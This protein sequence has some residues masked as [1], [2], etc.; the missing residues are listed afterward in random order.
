M[1]LDKDNDV[2]YYIFK[3]VIKLGVKIKDKYQNEWN[4][5]E[6]KTDKL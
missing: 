6:Y 1:H 2:I 3:I 4:L 5:Y